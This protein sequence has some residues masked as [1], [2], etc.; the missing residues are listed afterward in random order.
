M[1]TMATKFFPDIHFPNVPYNQTPVDM[2]IPE[3][4]WCYADIQGNTKTS[5]FD[6]IKF[7]NNQQ[8]EKIIFKP[9]PHGDD[10]FKIKNIDIDILQMQKHIMLNCNDWTWAYNRNKKQ[11]L[12]FTTIGSE[13][14]NC[15]TGDP[16]LNT[17]RWSK[18]ISQKIS[19]NFYKQHNCEYVYSD[20]YKLFKLDEN[21]Y[22]KLL[23]FIKEEP[24]ID[25]K[26]TIT[27]YVNTIGLEI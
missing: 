6:Y 19:E 20:P 27:E 3:S 14:Y 12:Q 13:L 15:L 8:K 25:W 16:G 22:N 11:V 18:Q 5:F 10:A 26:E 23:T 4:I 24:L 17:T 1:A 21:E 7:F 2:T 9:V